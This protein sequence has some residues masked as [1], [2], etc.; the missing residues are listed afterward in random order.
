M[1]VSKLLPEMR[2]DGDCDIRLYSGLVELR[3]R[4]NSIKDK[5][6]WCNAI[7][8]SMKQNE[9]QSRNQIA[10]TSLFKSIPLP[11]ESRP[12]FAGSVFNRA[13]DTEANKMTLSNRSKFN[14]ILDP[15]QHRTTKSIQDLN[16]ASNELQAMK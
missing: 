5:I 7:S 12:S 4:A 3:L 14:K 11:R 1:A 9:N 10:S 8:R 6:D 15:D 16:K 2:T 13:S